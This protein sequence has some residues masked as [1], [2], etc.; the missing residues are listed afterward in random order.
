MNYTPIKYMYYDVYHIMKLLSLVW[1]FGTP[2]TGAY[3]A[4]QSLG[5]SR[6]EYW[7]GL[8]FPSPDGWGWSPIKCQ[9]NLYDNCFKL[10]VFT[11]RLKKYNY[12]WGEKN[13][14][15]CSFVDKDKKYRRLQ[16]LPAARASVYSTQVIK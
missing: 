4:P 16:N 3:H 9:P 12:S 2:W 14:V 8:P 10:G 1:L 11:R 6:Q 7:S 15:E 13:T 5:F